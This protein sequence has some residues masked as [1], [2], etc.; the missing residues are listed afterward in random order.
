VLGRIEVI[1]K[2]QVAQ[3]Y[4]YQLEHCAALAA[5]ITLTLPSP[6]LRTMFGTSLSLLGFHLL[7]G[8]GKG[9]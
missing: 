8:P 9:K 6:H 7:H 2:M 4:L 3:V 1:K 5:T